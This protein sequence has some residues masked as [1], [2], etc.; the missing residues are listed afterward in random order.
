MALDNG[1]SSEVL[2]RAFRR[3]W[4][5]KISFK[6]LGFGDEGISRSFPDIL[7]QEATSCVSVENTVSLLCKTVDQSRACFT[8]RGGDLRNNLNYFPAYQT[9]T[10]TSQQNRQMKGSVISPCTGLIV[11]KRKN[12]R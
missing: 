2:L 12:G 9:Q 3:F 5:N 1:R 11:S 4:P 6:I 8:E 7:A 10:Q